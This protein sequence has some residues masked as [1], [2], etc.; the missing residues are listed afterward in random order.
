V[1]GLWLDNAFYFETTPSTVKGRNLAR[2][3]SI[4]VHTQDG[5]DTVILEGTAS[6]E[7]RP[8]VLGKL[9]KGYAAKYDYTPNWSRS[10]GDSVYRVDPRVVHAWRAPRMH[11]SIV[12]FVF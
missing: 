8:E 1:W 9:Q 2:N 6:M 10:D 7:K 3:P 11:Q 5:Y 12:K 4:V